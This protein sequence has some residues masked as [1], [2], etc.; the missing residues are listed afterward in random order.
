MYVH[1]VHPGIYFQ[2]QNPGKLGNYYKYCSDIS[3]L[4][5]ISNSKLITNNI[6]TFIIHICSSHFTVKCRFL[7]AFLAFFII[8]GH[9][10]IILNK[11]FQN[12]FNKNVRAVLE[13]S[14][15]IKSFQ[16]LEFK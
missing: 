3:I 14:E 13:L 10:F 4:F 7:S 15:I 8:K 12:L 9:I 2:T 5:I 1:I 11:N 6:I 16:K